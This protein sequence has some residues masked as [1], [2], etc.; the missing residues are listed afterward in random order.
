MVRR[1]K[2]GGI[3]ASSAQLALLMLESWW[4][5][6]WRQ[7]LNLSGCSQRSVELTAGHDGYEG[8][9]IIFILIIIIIIITSPNKLVLSK[10]ERHDERGINSEEERMSA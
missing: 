10:E 3:R 5:Q 9:F 7:T 6:P 8:F 1:E 2:A 4:E